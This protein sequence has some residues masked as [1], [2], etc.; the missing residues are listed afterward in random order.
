MRLIHEIERGSNLDLIARGVIGAVNRFADVIGRGLQ[1]IALAL[2]TPHDNSETVQAEIDK[3]TQ[4]LN[5]STDKVEA[6][7]EQ[8]KGE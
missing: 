4:Q 1:A 2:S 8:Q 6:A 7:I 5:A 3:I